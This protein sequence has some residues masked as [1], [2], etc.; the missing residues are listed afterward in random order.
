MVI[1]MVLTNVIPYKLFCWPVPRLAYFFALFTICLLDLHG[2]TSLASKVVYTFATYR[3]DYSAVLRTAELPLDYV[4]LPD[5]P[6]G[7]LLERQALLQ[8]WLL[9]P[10]RFFDRYKYLEHLQRFRSLGEKKFDLFD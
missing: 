6:F 10:G 1:K 7:Q 9:T 4:F 3:Q 5:T 8:R 2:E